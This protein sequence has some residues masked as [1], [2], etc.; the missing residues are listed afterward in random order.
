VVV[1][2]PVT[3]ADRGLRSHIELD[4]DES[5]LRHTSFAKAEDVRSISEARLDRRVGLLGPE[6]MHELGRALRLLLEL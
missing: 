2:V 6:R 4:A 1:V 5:G 3:T